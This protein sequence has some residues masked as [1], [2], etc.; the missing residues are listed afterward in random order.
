M[1]LLEAEELSVAELAAIT[2]LAQPRVSTH[3]A[4][5]KEAGLVCDR[6]AGVSVYYRA[7]S[8]EPSSPAHALWRTLA[9]QTDDPLLQQDLDHIDRVLAE[10][11]KERNW[12]DSVAGDME[13]HYSP[14]RTWETTARAL[15][16]LLDLG[17]VLDIAAGDGVTAELLAAQSRSMVCVDSSDKVIEAG[18]QRTREIDN[19]SYHK[20][21][22]HALPLDDA[23]FDT[24]LM[25][26][27]LTYS[28]EPARA[29][30][31]A[32][33]VLRPGGMLLLA[34]LERHSHEQIV[35]NY[36][37]LNHGFTAG[38]LSSM[39]QQAGLQSV[40]VKQATRESRPP[41]FTVLTLTAC[42]H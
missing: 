23:S 21:D 15:M 2:H 38:E 6:R 29:V 19:V 16:R 8:G 27:A 5:L 35:A 4:R 12:A 26:H 20:A 3:L 24:V 34:T 31:E 25:L 28:R 42:K 18:Q 41:H 30:A 37:H 32:A 40:R 9:A 11:S 33:R 14:G 10:R 1:H 39:A 7:T 17:D 36:D 13:R 22:M